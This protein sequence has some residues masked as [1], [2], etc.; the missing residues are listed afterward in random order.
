M[1]LFRREEAVGPQSLGLVGR[2]NFSLSASA[3]AWTAADLNLEGPA[4]EK[5]GDSSSGPD[6]ASLINS[7]PDDGS[8]PQ[9][10]S[11]DRPCAVG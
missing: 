11:Q 7:L 3:L 5:R 10:T 2:R 8:A 9:K 4:G 1:Y 6:Q